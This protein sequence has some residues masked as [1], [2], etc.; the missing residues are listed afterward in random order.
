MMAS[1]GISGKT[2]IKSAHSEPIGPNI[3]YDWDWKYV[4][5]TKDKMQWTILHPW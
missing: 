1:P 2:T 3:V 4:L 5:S